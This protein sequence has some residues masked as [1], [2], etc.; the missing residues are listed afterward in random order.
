MWILQTSLPI[1]EL[2]EISIS[3]DS[4][5]LSRLEGNSAEHYEILARYT[6]MIIRLV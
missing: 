5:E 2:P 1:Y 6:R 3:S 4:K